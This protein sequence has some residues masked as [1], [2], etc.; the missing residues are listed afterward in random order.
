MEE[1]FD[2]VLKAL[3]PFEQNISS[4]TH[5]DL[6][7]SLRNQIDNS[8]KLLTILYRLEED[9]LISISGQPYFHVSIKDRGV[10]KLKNG[11]YIGELKRERRTFYLTEI[12]YRWVVVGSA[13]AILL[14]LF[15]ILKSFCLN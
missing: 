14:L 5:A 1:T 4:I 15:E 11:G 8:D 7:K 13:A 6:F 10:A 2:L 3:L 9:K 12:T